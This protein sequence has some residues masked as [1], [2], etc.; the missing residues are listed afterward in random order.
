MTAHY[1]PN[2]AGGA[3]EL[4]NRGTVLVQALV[5]K[6]GRVKDVRNHKC[7]PELD[8]AAVAAVKQWIIK[9]AQLDGRPVAVWV[10]VPV[11]FSLHETAHRPNQHQRRWAGTGK[12]PPPPRSDP[13]ARPPCC[14]RVRR[15]LRAAEVIGWAFSSPHC[16]SQSLSGRACLPR[17]SPARTAKARLLAPRVVRVRV[18][19]ESGLDLLGGQPLVN[20]PGDDRPT[21][22][23]GVPRVGSRKST[24]ASSARAVGS[25]SMLRSG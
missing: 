25:G 3:T 1:P 7:I 17:S 20:G 15:T 24:L 13:A 21:L 12:H 6:D 19:T 4:S 22:R 9:P 8:A 23:R 14:T 16:R 2:P 18:H 5:G 11:K 10:A